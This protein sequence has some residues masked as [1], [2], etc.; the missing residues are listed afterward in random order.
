MFSFTREACWM[1]GRGN[2]WH[3]HD[4]G[5]QTDSIRLPSSTKSLPSWDHETNIFLPFGSQWLLQSTQALGEE[6]QSFLSFFFF[7]PNQT[8]SMFEDWSFL[9]P[10][11][12]D[13]MGQLSH[14][15]LEP[16]LLGSVPCS[17]E[18]RQHVS[19]LQM[20]ETETWLQWLKQVL[21]FPGV[22]IVAAALQGSLSKGFWC[23]RGPISPTFLLH[24]H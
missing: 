19:V 4:Q 14:S 18:I 20:R 16:G 17:K 23:H 13:I 11:W 12:S 3:E 10:K 15:C 8:L 24:H 22:R 9:N 1:V 7:L 2:L 21:Y 5:A 6:S